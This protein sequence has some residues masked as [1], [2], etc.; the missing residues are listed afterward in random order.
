MQP[1]VLV[2]KQLS[3]WGVR[4]AATLGWDNWSHCIRRSGC[5][6]RRSLLLAH[7]WCWCCTPIPVLFCIE[8][9]HPGSGPRWRS[10]LASGIPQTPVMVA[11]CYT[12]RWWYRSAPRFLTWRTSMLPPRSSYASFPSPSESSACLIILWAIKCFE[13]YSDMTV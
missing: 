1:W 2:V 9:G 6:S 7:P 8:H 11:M 4:D 10:I 5:S 12:P 13:E 3:S